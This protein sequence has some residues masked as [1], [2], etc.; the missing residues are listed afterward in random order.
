MAY[1]DRF[2]RPFIECNRDISST[3]MRRLQF[4][5][6]AAAIAECAGKYRRHSRTQTWALDFVPSGESR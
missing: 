3:E 6:W 1:R 4:Q 5:G 2:D